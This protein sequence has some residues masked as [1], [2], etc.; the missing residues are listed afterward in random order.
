MVKFKGKCVPIRKDEPF[1]EQTDTGRLK[2]NLT[3]FKLESRRVLP[4]PPPKLTAAGG[5]GPLLKVLP[6]G[7][8]VP[9]KSSPVKKMPTANDQG[10][11]TPDA[12][13]RR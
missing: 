5:A 9:R 12:E 11:A 3:F 4:V 10:G 1:E 13:R 2:Q 8:G 7:T 6:P